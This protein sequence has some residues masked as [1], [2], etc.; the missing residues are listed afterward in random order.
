MPVCCS[1]SQVTRPPLPLHRPRSTRAADRRDGGAK[2]ELSSLP[3]CTPAVERWKVSWTSS[4]NGCES[5]LPPLPAM[6]STKCQAPR[7]AHC[8][9]LL[10]ARETGADG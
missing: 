3:S 9:K 7:F 8:Q 4:S 1:A 6:C 2:K 10:S 5:T